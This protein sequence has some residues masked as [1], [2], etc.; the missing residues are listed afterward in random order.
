MVAFLEEHIAGQ[1]FCGMGISSLCAYNYICS[2]EYE[3]MRD[4]KGQSLDAV[5]SFLEQRGASSHS[6]SV[7][8][9]LPTFG[10]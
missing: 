5:E 10:L 6:T 3:D 1:I 4:D 9:L 8:E 2:D 7:C